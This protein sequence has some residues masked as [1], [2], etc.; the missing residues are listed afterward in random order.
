MKLIFSLLL[1]LGSLSGVWAQSNLT[2][3]V[4]DLK[5]GEALTGAN[6]YLLEAR[7]GASAN[8]KGVYNI[9]GL[10]PGTYTMR[11]TYVGF[12]QFFRTVQIMPNIER[13]V[14]HVQMKESALE[15]EALVV[16]AVRAGKRDPFAYST[17][18]KEELEVLNLGQDVPYLLQWTPSVVVTSDA[19]AGIGYTGMRI[20]GS[21]P[22]RINVTINGIPLNDSE[23]QNVFWVNMPDFASSTED[24][25]IQ[26]GVGTSTNG[27]GAFGASINLSTNTTELE[28]YVRLHNSAGSFNTLR[29]S[30]QFGTGLVGK[31]FTFSGRLSQIRSDGYVDRASSNLRS[32]YLSAGYV[33]EKRSLRFN[34]FS[35]SEVTYQ[36][37]DGISPELAADRET[38]TTNLAGSQRPGEPHPNEVDDYQQTHYQLHYNEQ[39]T[40]NW[41]LNL[42]L[43]YTRGMGFFEQYRSDQSLGNYLLP[44]VVLGNDTIRRTDLIRRRWLDNHFYGTVYSAMY[45]SNDNRLQLTF[46]GAWNDYLGDHFGEVI[47]ARFMSSGEQGHRYYENDARKMDFNTFVKAN[48]Q[49][50]ERVFAYGDLQYRRVDYRFEGPDNDG[51]VLDQQAVLDFFNPKAGVF[52]T[53]NDNREAF[54]SVAVAH[55]E[56][57]RSD[58]TD[59][60]P[61]SRPGAEKLYDLE[62]GFRQRG[63]AFNFELNAYYMYYRDQLV[64]SGRL[65]DVGAYTRI[66]VPESYRAGL[67][68]SGRLNVTNSF[69]VQ[70]NATL[71]QN[72][73]VEF[74]EYVDVY[75]SEFNW[76]GQTL[77]DREGSDLAFSPNLIAAL[78]LGYTFFQKPAQPGSG[79]EVALLN[80][81][82]GSQ[83]LDNSS[84]EALRLDAYYTTDLRL[85]YALNPSWC[86]YLH[87]SF[88]VQNVFDHLYASNGWAYR[89]QY[90]GAFL[91]D[92]GLYPQATRNFLVGLNI[93]LAGKKQ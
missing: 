75:D 72:R 10:A 78:E 17:V 47:W 61:S 9:T 91:Q 54:A 77:I 2:G 7:T 76:T 28:P 32:Y 37:W 74:T 11:V 71:S 89:Y 85:R 50:S 4:T 69:H 34:L 64:L 82:V 65:N 20:R 6:V 84:D 27:A 16:R 53:L 80:K 21:D 3:Q 14:I 38:R 86:D 83:F 39:L 8:D 41:S 48:Y 43:H 36:A 68:L 67:E 12:E 59:A 46:G 31:G 30:V 19:G 35:G 87:L 42:A 29:N 33:G 88:L 25:Q 13:H 24:I 93:G 15:L 26:R 49:L 44:E 18:G 66:N 70:G 22:T 23:S 90:E 55:R 63:Q 62:L 51:L 56:P 52:V 73:I 1:V 81:Y 40:R 57:N 60:S 58:F 45:Q 92:I 5:T 79:L